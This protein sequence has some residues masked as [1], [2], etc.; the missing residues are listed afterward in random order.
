MAPDVP[1]LRLAG[2]VL[3]GGRSKRF[4]SEKAVALFRGRPMLDWSLDALA[5]VCGAVAVSAR[6]ESAAADL[7][8]G[9]GLPVL[10]DDPDIPEG[11][12]AGIAAG[13]AWARNSGFTHLATLPCDAP[14]VGAEQLR[15]LIAEAAA[16]GAFAV[17]P[18]G[19]QPLIAIWPVA[20]FQ[21]PRG[22]HPP[23]RSLLL[24]LDALPVFYES[25]APFTNL[26]QPAG[27]DQDRANR[28]E[29]VSADADAML[30]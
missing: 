14:L 1:P 26:N 5:T 18:D 28:P 21:R 27:M 24:T 2:L 8:R 13:I 16:T 22:E 4:G 11:P 17:T 20:A 25:A 19:P 9:R 15:R 7:A 12:L 23:T 3:A 29:T 30:I 6:A 10:A